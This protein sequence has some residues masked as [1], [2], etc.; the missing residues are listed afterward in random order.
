MGE[1]W[2]TCRMLLDPFGHAPGRSDRGEAT[3]IGSGGRCG[4]RGS[5]SVRCPGEHEIRCPRPGGTHLLDQLTAADFEGLISAPFAFASQPNVPPLRLVSVERLPAQP[6]APRPQP[7][8][9][10]FVSDRGVRLA[11][12]IHALEH[13]TLGPLDLFLVPIEPGPDGLPR[14]EAVFN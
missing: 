7:F 5:A 3:R 8:S 1:A 10:V 9:L 13:P 11:Q 4:R 6:R 2:I 14:Y 12:Q